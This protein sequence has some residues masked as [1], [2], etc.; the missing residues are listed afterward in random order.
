MEREKKV[1]D[2][3]VVVKWFLNEQDSAKA[4]KLRD[5][6]ANGKTLLIVPDLLFIEVLNTLRYKEHNIKTISQAN[7]L[8]WEMQ[9]HVEKT[10][11]FLLE[12]ALQAAVT[13]NLSL[14]DALYAAV[15]GIFGIPLVTADKELQKIPNT[16]MLQDY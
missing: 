3:S 15:A 13:H 4:L 10:N 6:H 9:L 11:K 5:D 16:V 8:L 2:A 7:T 14:Y 1:V 12:K